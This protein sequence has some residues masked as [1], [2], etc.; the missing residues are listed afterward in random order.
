[1]ATEA[2]SDFIANRIRF[3]RT[4]HDAFVKR[5]HRSRDIVNEG[6]LPAVRIPYAAFAEQ[7][8]DKANDEPKEHPPF[9][10]RVHRG[11]HA[12][13]SRHRTFRRHKAIHQSRLPGNFHIFRT[14]I[15]TLRD[16]DYA[17]RHA[18]YIMRSDQKMPVFIY[19]IGDVVRRRQ[20]TR[21]DWDEFHLFVHQRTPFSCNSA[22]RKFVPETRK[23]VRS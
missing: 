9:A 7:F 2:V 10:F 1:M 15:A 16:R 18:H 21:R 14:H 13:N 19:D 3:I 11:L 17:F 4:V 6:C 8:R 22:W 12:V 20:N 5:R 23:R